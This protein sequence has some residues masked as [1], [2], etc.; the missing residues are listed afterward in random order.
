MQKITLYDIIADRARWQNT[1]MLRHDDKVEYR[2]KKEYGNRHAVFEKGS[3]I[4]Y[5]HVDKFNA[6]DLPVGTIRHIGKFVEEK[7]GIP[8]SI[9]SLVIG[10]LGIA[11]IAYA[12]H[13]GY[14]N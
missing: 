12:C 4:G 8:E 1:S 11:G 5:V 9:T 3:C 7:T 6:T 14:K 10:I 13:K 2:E